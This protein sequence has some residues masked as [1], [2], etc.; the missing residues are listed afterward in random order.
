MLSDL[1]SAIDKKNVEK[2]NDI[3][4]YSC[5]AGIIGLAIFFRSQG[6]FDGNIS[7]WW[8]E[9]YWGDKLI[10]K[11]LKEVIRIRP[12]GF[13]FLTKLL[14]N[15]SKDETV[16]RLVSYLSSILT[17]PL[18]FLIAKR[19]WRSKKVILLM[20]FIIAFSPIL[21]TFAKEFK[22]YAL[23]FFIHTCFIYLSLQ[24]IYSKKDY[25]L[26]AIITFA[27]FS[28]F[29]CYT[30]VFIFPAIFLILLFDAYSNRNHRKLALIIATILII[31]VQLYLMYYFIF[32]ETS[33][34][35]QESYWGKKYD[36]F[37]LGSS[38][39]E[40][41]KWVVSKYVGLVKHSGR[42]EVFWPGASLFTPVIGILLLIF[43]FVGILGFLL[44]RKFN[45]L[46]LF[47][48]PIVTVILINFFGVWPW[49]PFRVNLFLLIYFLILTVNGFDFFLN[50]KNRIS[51]YCV[52]SIVVVFFFHAAAANQF[53]LL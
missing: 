16:F 23:D 12:V 47:F 25:L 28:I 30:I 33:V 52:W 39:I 51:R 13:M 45:Y 32:S 20:L 41:F 50:K 10:T 17:I 49:G 40:Q 14:I 22:P 34:A 26:Y 15:I 9:A 31:F 43:H 38:F 1:T 48:L 42:A 27:V 36:V 18:I 4:F 5:I 46:L 24:Y 29:F 11:P 37:Y 53:P 3:F 44:E 6:Y 19:I 35:D 21:I 8:D 7:F 2:R